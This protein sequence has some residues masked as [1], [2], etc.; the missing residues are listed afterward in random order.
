MLLVKLIAGIILLAAAALIFL[1]VKSD[2]ST[3]AVFILA[4]MGVYFL[5]TS[6]QDAM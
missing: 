1:F 6:K 2:I 5:A 3:V 4:G